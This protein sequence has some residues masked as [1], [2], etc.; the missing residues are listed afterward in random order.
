MDSTI[1]STGN[2]TLS[3][4]IA[5]H[6]NSKPSES[7]FIVENANLS[8]QQYDELS[9]SLAAVLMQCGFA[10]GE[11]VGL[12]LPDGCDI[13]VAFVACE[14]AGLVAVGL[15]PRAAEKEIT[16]LL[17]V[18]GA[19]ALVSEPLHGQR[20]TDVLYASLL[21]AGIPLRHHVTLV[22]SP[23]KSNSICVDQIRQEVALDHEQINELIRTRHYSVDDF[24]LLNS[25]SGTTGMPK[26]VMHNQRRWFYFAQLVQEG[27]PLS[28]DDVFFSAL[29]ASVGFGLWTA[30]FVPTM[31]GIPVVLLP[32]FS[33][34]EML[35][36]IERH[37]VTVLAAVT[38]Q[39]IMMLND[40]LLNNTGFDALRI[41]YTGGEAVPYD[42]AAAFEDRTGARVLQFYG[43]NETGA[44]CHTTMRDTRE[45]RL[46]TAGRVVESMNVRLIN[47]HGEDVT[48]SGAGQPVCKGPLLSLGYFNNEQANINLYTP[49]GWMKTGDIVTLDD[50]NY[51][52]VV[53][54]VDDVI[55][56]GGKNISAAAVEE[57]V[58]AHPDVCLVAAI[59]KPDHVFGER[60]CVYLEL[61]EGATISKESLAQFLSEKS[62]S[63]EYFPE[64]I[65]VMEKLPIASGGKIAKNQLREDMKLRSE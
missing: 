12:L 47:E 37:Q 42:R 43:S 46:R 53:G 40:P 45:Q 61:A 15:S 6:A 1:N 29:P 50:Q 3:E 49:D 60:V 5:D 31:L 16:H 2:I 32:D 35:L 51:L 4:I 41:L 11:R 52:T 44:L 8:W 57:A 27:S 64:H 28:S 38:T 63:K 30:H 26:S 23:H 7:A 18:A 48:R 55:I 20:A 14:K 19:V 62:I 21:E 36:A 56:R 39:F 17:R 34:R 54:R 59:A 65:V 58:V 22:G 10:Q 25:T 13:H 33:A 9:T 24:F